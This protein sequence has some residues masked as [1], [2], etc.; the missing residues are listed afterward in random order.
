MATSHATASG[1]DLHELFHEVFLL[2]GALS[3]VVDSVHQRAGLRTSQCKVA[4]VL[5][6][7][8]PASVPDIAARLDVSRQ[9]IQTMCNEF[10]Q[11]GFVE[12]RDSPRHKRS[13]L[14]VLTPKGKR[15]LEKAWAYEAS[16]IE[17][18]FQRIPRSETLAA[19]GLLKRLRE[20][21]ASAVL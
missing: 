21:L 6:R 2:H 3:A 10:E 1:E 15:A 4:D 8:G 18:T 20:I 11:L 9:F 5:D 7:G 19:T 13:K 14:V 16:V 17:Q 12:F